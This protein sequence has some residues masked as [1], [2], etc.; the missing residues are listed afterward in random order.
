MMTRTAMDNNLKI[1]EVARTIIS[2]L[3]SD[4]DSN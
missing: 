2:T 3:D 1:Q 4:G